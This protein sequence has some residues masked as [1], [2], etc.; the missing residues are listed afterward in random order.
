MVFEGGCL[1]AAYRTPSTPTISG[2][3]VS[4]RPLDS[5][6]TVYVVGGCAIVSA[7]DADSPL[8]VPAQGV[9]FGAPKAAQGQ[10]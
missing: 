10:S 4:F 5:K 6:D 1:V 7:V 9:R 3:Y 8:P 2:N